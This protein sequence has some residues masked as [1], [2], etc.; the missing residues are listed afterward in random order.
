MAFISIIIFLL[1]MTLLGKPVWR[2]GFEW[3]FSSIFLSYIGVVLFFGLDALLILNL[4]DQLPIK[5]KSWHYEV[6][7]FSV[8]SFLFN[9][10]SNSSFVNFNKNEDLFSNCL[11]LLIKSAKF[12]LLL[13]FVFVHLLMV[14]YHSHISIYLSSLMSLPLN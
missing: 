9:K 12:N 1:G 6:I 4:N 10:L 2:E 13:F 7:L 11:N 3:E 8:M 14:Y 5:R